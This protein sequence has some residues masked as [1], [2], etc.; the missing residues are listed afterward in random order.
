LGIE[1]GRGRIA[2]EK[3]KVKRGEERGR[4]QR[5]EKDETRERKRKGRGKGKGGMLYSCDFSLGEILEGVK[6]V[7]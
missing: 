7:D 3:R 6:I 1:K 4:G 2:E 5:E